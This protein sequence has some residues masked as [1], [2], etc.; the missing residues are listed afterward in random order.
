MTFNCCV[1]IYNMGKLTWNIAFILLLSSLKRKIFY[2]K[3]SDF[4]RGMIKY[5]TVT[6]GMSCISHR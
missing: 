3:W 2:E 6:S 5:N 4:E 1:L